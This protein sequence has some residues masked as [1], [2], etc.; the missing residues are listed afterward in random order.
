MG[1]LP[2][3]APE[4]IPDI[5]T[6]SDEYRSRSLP[7]RSISPRTRNA[8][9]LRRPHNARGDPPRSGERVLPPER[10]AK[11]LPFRG[12]V[13]RFWRLTERSLPPQRAKPPSPSLRSRCAHR[14]WQSVSPS[15]PPSLVQKWG[16]QWGRSPL[17]RRGRGPRPYSPEYGAAPFSRCLKIPAKRPSQIETICFDLKRRSHRAIRSFR[18]I[19]VLRKR[20]ERRALRRGPLWRFLSP[21]SFPLKEMGSRRS[22]K[23]SRPDHR[24]RRSGLTSPPLRGPPP[25]KGRLRGKD[26]PL[27]RFAVLLP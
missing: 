15:K 27:H 3:S 12:A 4:R 2:V 14:L 19:T 25:L 8:R 20:S 18:S 26:H 5:R 24:P 6:R 9:C 13:S 22:A 21:I 16:I 7:A 23:R 11:R 1:I 17:G 10:A